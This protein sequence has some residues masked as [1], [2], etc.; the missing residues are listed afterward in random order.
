MK[1]QAFFFSVKDKPVAVVIAEAHSCHKKVN[2]GIGQPFEKPWSSL[3]KNNDIPDRP[4]KTSVPI[5]ASL[6]PTYLSEELCQHFIV[7]QLFVK[8]LAHNF[9]CPEIFLAEWEQIHAVCLLIDE[10]QARFGQ[11]VK[12]VLFEFS[13]KDA[14]LNPY[15]AVLFARLGHLVPRFVFADV[16]DYPDEYAHDFAPILRFSGSLKFFDFKP[17]RSLF[18]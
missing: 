2:R 5:R 8:A 4:A 16:I 9:Y 18:P 6:Q 11:F 7:Y 13:K 12:P 10:V 3:F 15:Q 17:P 14:L 1:M